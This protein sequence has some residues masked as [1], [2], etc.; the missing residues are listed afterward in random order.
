[1]KEHPTREAAVNLTAYLRSIGGANGVGKEDKN[2]VRSFMRI[3]GIQSNTG[4]YGVR[5]ARVIMQ[6]GL[7]PVVP[8]YWTD[9]RAEKIA[10][11]HLI[12]EFAHT[13]SQRASQWSALLKDIERV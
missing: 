6:Q 11:V 7:V 5:T 3:L 9:K 4:S 8:Y 10:L 2:K 12:K 1:M 13:D